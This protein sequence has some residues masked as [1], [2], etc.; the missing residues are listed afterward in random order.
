MTTKAGKPLFAFFGTLRFAL[1]VLDALEAHGFL[2][3][4]IITAP[5]KPAGRGMER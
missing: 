1:R 5:D 3:A 4:L 2:P